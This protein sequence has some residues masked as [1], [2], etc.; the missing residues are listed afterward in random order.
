MMLVDDGH[1]Y[2]FHTIV[3]K[4]S[5]LFCCILHIILML[6]PSRSSQHLFLFL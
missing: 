5:L 6:Y 4:L 1:S 3:S 2:R